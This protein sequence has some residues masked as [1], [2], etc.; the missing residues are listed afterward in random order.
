MSS[1][2]AA[3]LRHG[4][5]RRAALAEHRA[6]AVRRFEVLLA[7]AVA[8]GLHAHRRHRAEARDEMA[9]QR[10]AR[11]GAELA[12]HRPAVDRDVPQEQR[13]RRCGDGQNPVRAA[14]LPAPDVDRRGDDL[15]PA[16]AGASAGTPPSRRP[17]AS[18]VPTSW[19]WISSTGTPWTRLSASAIRPVD[20]AACR[21]CTAAADAG[22][23]ARYAQYRAGRCVGDGGARRGRG[24]AMLMVMLMMGHARGHDG[25]S[26]RTPLAVDSRDMC[27]PPMPHLTAASADV[28]HA[29]EPQRVQFA[30]QKRLR[31]RQQLQ[32]RRR[33]HIARRAHRRSPDIKS[34]IVSSLQ[35]G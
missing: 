5:A 23:R 28:L 29:R 2:I 11:R 15:H 34:F 4:V 21:R 14:H 27:V 7:H 12:A 10:R 9:Q 19:K 3:Q 17:R 31:I 33:Q 25:A 18:S 35:Y 6:H 1:T 24:H 20:R 13:R 8:D 16:P 26:P 30:S 32:Q 22:A